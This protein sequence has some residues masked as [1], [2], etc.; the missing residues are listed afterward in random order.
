MLL[1]RFVINL[2]TS[3]LSEVGGFGGLAGKVEIKQI[4]PHD[5]D[6]NRYED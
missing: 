4:I 1:E 3:L 2:Q 6:V 5:G